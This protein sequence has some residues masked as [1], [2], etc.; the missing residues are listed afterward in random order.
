M[1]YL[2]KFEA[3]SENVNITNIID[4][5]YNYKLNVLEFKCPKKFLDSQIKSYTLD[6]YNRD[7]NI[8]KNFDINLLWD[9]SFW[10]IGPT[11]SITAIA[12][13]PYTKLKNLLSGEPTPNYKNFHTT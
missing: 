9:R 1:K 7:L 12:S 13:I 5:A 4:K 11:S 8:L 10:K 3:Y 6:D 2:E